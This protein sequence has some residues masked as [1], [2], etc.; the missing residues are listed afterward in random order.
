MHLRDEFVVGQRPK[1]KLLLFTCTVF[2][3]ELFTLH[4]GG[5]S[6]AFG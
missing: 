5:S 2:A 4:G 3:I 1:V 6:V